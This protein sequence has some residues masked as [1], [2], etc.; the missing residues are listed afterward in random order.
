MDGFGRC[1]QGE[2]EYARVLGQLLHEFGRQCLNGRK[3]ARLL[4]AKSVR[5]RF[6][7]SRAAVAR[8]PVTHPCGR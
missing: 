7:P 8:Y 3:T 2:V 5:C 4:W 1:E 6:G